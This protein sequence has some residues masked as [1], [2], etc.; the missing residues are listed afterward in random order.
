M[1][2]REFRQIGHE[3]ADLLSEYFEH[4]EEKPVSRMSRRKR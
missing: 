3:V 2:T 1:D 4:I